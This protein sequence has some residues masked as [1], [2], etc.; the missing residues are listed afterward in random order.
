MLNRAAVEH[1]I[2]LEH[3][4]VGVHADLAHHLTQTVLGRTDRVDPESVEASWRT[5][6]KQALRFLVYCD[7]SPRRSDDRGGHEIK[8]SNVETLQ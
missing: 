6:E 3:L 2:D 4:V 5:L 7:Q 8:S 1:A